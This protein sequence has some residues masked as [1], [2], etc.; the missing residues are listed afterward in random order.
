MFFIQGKDSGF[1][2]R[3]RDK[4]NSCPNRLGEIS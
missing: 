4:E 1:L 2:L 3:D